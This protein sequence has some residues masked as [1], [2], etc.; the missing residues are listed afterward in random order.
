MSKLVKRITIAIVVIALIS[1]A[2]YFESKLSKPKTAAGNSKTVKAS[3]TKINPQ[4]L[5][6]T[7]DEGDIALA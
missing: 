6:I 1:S 2:F 3:T 4:D 7:N 5:L